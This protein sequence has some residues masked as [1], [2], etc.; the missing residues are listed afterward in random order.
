MRRL[1]RHRAA[2]AL[3]VAAATTAGCGSD[4]TTG[5]PTT[6]TVTTPRTT[7]TFTG[8]IN[9]SNAHTYPFVSGAGTLTVTLNSVAPDS[10][11]AIGISIGTWNGTTC[12]VGTGLFN[13]TAIQGST[14]TGQVTT[15]GNL[16][17]RVYDG[18]GQVVAPTTYTITVI[19]P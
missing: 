8:T 11:I 15:T 4:T 7:E 6:P 3:L 10:A 1:I 18:A 14:L 5:T 12:T 13:D 2:A 16:C 19:H 17:A 9:T